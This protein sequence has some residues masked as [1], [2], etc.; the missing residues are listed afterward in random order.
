M[1]L[2]P[3]E[4]ETRICKSS[5]RNSFTLIELLV[6]VAIIAV[7]AA[8]LLPALQRAKERGKQIA[9]M[10]NLRQ[11][12]LGFYLF[13]DDYDGYLPRGESP[14]SLPWPW[15]NFVW[16]AAAVIYASGKPLPSSQNDAYM[17][18]FDKMFMCP[19]VN[20]KQYDGS[21]CCWDWNDWGSAN[22]YSPNNV[23]CGQVKNSYGYSA[24]LGWSYGA[25][26]FDKRKLGGAKDG[27][28][29]LITEASGLVWDDGWWT[30][31]AKLRHNGGLNV[32]FEDGR[33]E[34][35]KGDLNNSSL[36]IKYMEWHDETT[37]DGTLN[38]YWQKYYP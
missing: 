1:H 29:A 13:A 38:G 34:W 12:G 3:N 11:V 16:Q 8:M 33:V 20:L 30:A 35:R 5:L 26:W 4:P 23:Y 31:R 28:K 18:Q 37:A 36:A 32:L 9:C 10:N 25:G 7:L 17:A 6:V 24:W 2:V 14:S 19:S 27:P 15:S 21:G 22:I